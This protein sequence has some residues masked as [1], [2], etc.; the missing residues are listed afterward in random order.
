[1][2][3]RTYM[4]IDLKSFYASA[5]CSQLG[6]D[7]FKTNLVVA[8]PSR[9]PGAICLAIT[10]A[11]KALGIKNR[12]RLNEIPR[13]V[14]Y[15]TAIPRMNMYMRISAHIYG[16]YLKYIAPEDINVYSIDEV[17]ID[18]TSYLL[19]YKKTPKEL[20]IMLMDKVFEETGITATAG[21]GTNMFLAKVALDITAKHVP[22]HIGILDEEEFKRTVQRHEPITDIWGI[23]PGTA[24]RLA[25][26][27]AKN[28]Y[29][30]TLMSE[31]LLKRLFGVNYEY[32]LD[33]A[34]GIEPCTIADILK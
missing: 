31:S 3:D 29:D 4:C 6:L 13:S 1:M 17:F 30:V 33:H 34:N 25:R 24:S 9:G 5:E 7:P 23:G 2:P 21:I 16:I 26:Y 28:L 27:G 22:D 20:A 15:I 12:C 11:M 32:L 18:A 8:D 14:E 10:P 19:L